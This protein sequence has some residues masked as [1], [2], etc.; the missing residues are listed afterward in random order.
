MTTGTGK[1]P[2]GTRGG[3]KINK[4]IPNEYTT[5][6]IIPGTFRYLHK[7]GRKLTR[8]ATNRTEAVQPRRPQRPLAVRRT[9]TELSE[10][11]ASGVGFVGGSRGQRNPAHPCVGVHA[12]RKTADYYCGHVSI[13]K[14]H[15]NMHLR[16]WAAVAVKGFP[17]VEVRVRDRVAESKKPTPAS[18]ER[19]KRKTSL[20]FPPGVSPSPR[21]VMGRNGKGCAFGAKLTYSLTS[22]GAA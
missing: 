22:W 15:I 4:R 9:S 7:T 10:L 20:P 19:P 13:I 16:S 18:T 1:L 3:K 2:Q 5:D 21:N 12:D 8:Y 14:L 11:L 17:R 6:L